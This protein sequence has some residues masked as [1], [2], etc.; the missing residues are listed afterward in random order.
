MSFLNQMI[1]DLEI[2][3]WINQRDGREAEEKAY[4]LEIQQKEMQTELEYESK[5]MIKEHED[6][7]SINNLKI[8]DLN[9]EFKKYRQEIKFEMNIKDHILD[10]I[11]NQGDTYKDELI[12]LRKII[13]NKKQTIR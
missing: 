6:N 13:M 10:K 3:C 4:S 7:V 2:L 5:K 9:N 11:K 1:N 12:L 8:N